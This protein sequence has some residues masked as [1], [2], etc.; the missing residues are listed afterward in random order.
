MSLAQSPWRHRV[1]GHDVQPLDHGWEAAVTDGS[2]PLTWLP[3]RV[4]GTT[5]GVLRD[6]GVAIGGDLDSQEW[7]FRTTFEAARAGSGEEVVLRLDGVATLAEVELNGERLLDIGSMFEPH[8]VEVGAR[9]RATNELVIRCLPLA[10]ALEVQ[11]K[12]RARWRTNLVADGRL[13]WFRTMI[14]G[15]APGFAP[16]P[17]AVGPWRPVWLVR[18]R[19]LV[20]EA[21]TL[22]PVLDGDAGVLRTEGRI[23]PLDGT[24]P[25][26]IR[27]ELDGPSGR[28]A[29][30]LELAPGGDD[31]TF[32]G[33]LRVP[34]VERW[35]P[36]THGVP[37]LHD[38]RLLVGTGTTSTTVEAGR[39]GFRTLTAG[40]GSTHDIERDGLDLHVSGIRTFARGALWT[41]TDIVGLATTAADLR[42]A[43]EAVRD[44]GMNMVRLPGTGAYETDGFYDLCDE[45][46]LLV[47]QDFMFA[48]LDYPF[49]DDAFRGLAEREATEVL[50]RLAGRPSTAVL[51]GNSEIE[52]QVAMLGLDP[53]LGRDAFFASTLPA[54][55][56]DAGSDAIYVPSAPFGGDLPFRPD[57][58]VANYYGVGGYRRPLTDARVAGVRFASE[59]LAFAN[60]PDDEVIESMLP[61]ATTGVVVHHPAWK[62]GVPRDVG[63][64][65]DF[66]D[67]RDHYLALLFEVD[68]GELRRVDHARYLALSRA[69]SGEVMAEVFGEW[70]R[71][72]S[73]SGGG[74]VLW[75][76]DLVA[77]AGWGVVDHRGAPKVAYHHLRRAL[78]PAAVWTT[79][80]GLG[81]I[82]AHV[83][84]DG[85]EPLDGRL[86]VAL[87]RDL[88]QRVGDGEEA[89]R[90]E[91][92]GSHERGVEDLVG[93]FADVSWAYRFGPPAQDVVVASLERDDGAAM[94]VLSQAFRFPAG[95]PSL[96]ESADRLGLSA[97]ARPCGEGVVR[98][99]VRSRRLA[100]GVRVHAPGYT[101]DDDAFSVEPGGSREVDLRALVPAAHFGGE[102]SAINLAGRV[103]I[104]AA[105]GA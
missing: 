30:A 39:V 83:A 41:P 90:I 52:Q 22:R 79:D 40:P 100:Y 45:L 46:G 102:I 66:D 62:A 54:L 96:V 92:H 103:P 58:G 63:T 94:T 15:R 61:G 14:L 17:P 97:D 81:G 91:A 24:T 34:S 89:L 19:G 65:W 11:R 73:P 101:P 87:Y 60:V 78:A 75:L 72:G 64:G 85:T 6:A 53:A 74:L 18:R 77:G 20:V 3:A 8:E 21:L 29:V 4:P 105:A 5:A 10:P 7:S 25:D 9:L 56:A 67:V 43:L 76:R 84:N 38:V 50:G 86:R 49:A 99:T 95:R 80:E 28:H 27:L 104:V 51:C 68:P 42:S 48:N 32:Q 98:M 47:W 13:R 69:V 59:C 35:W 88:E 57:R 12:P 44:A 93:H 26:S 37:A 55:A 1:D 82:V 2:D 16:G 70:R 33:T 23:R 36:H 71:A 31:T